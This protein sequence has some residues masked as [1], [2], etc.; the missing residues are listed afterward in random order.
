M[1]REQHGFALFVGEH[2]QQSHHLLLAGVVEEG[3]GLVKDDHWRLLCQCLRHHHF[4]SLAVAECCNVVLCKCCDAH[5]LHRLGHGGFVV[6][7]ECAPEVRVR[8]T[9]QCHHLFGCEIPHVEWV[10]EHHG[11]SSAPALC[12]RAQ[13]R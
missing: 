12:Q 2:L 8:G 7:T 3:G 11:N 6:L 4:L 5:Q 9:A 13:Q 10:G 1:R